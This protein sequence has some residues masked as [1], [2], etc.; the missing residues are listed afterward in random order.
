VAWTA[1]EQRAFTIEEL[2]ALI[3]TATGVDTRAVIAEWLTP[4]PW[5]P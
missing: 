5:R 3:Q 2:P 1:R 4:R